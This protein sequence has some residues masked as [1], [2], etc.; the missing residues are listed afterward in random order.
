MANI[1]NTLD[2]ERFP[3]NV[4][5]VYADENDEIFTNRTNNAAEDCKI[6]YK[7][8]EYKWIKARTKTINIF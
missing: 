7:F 6:N 3:V 5:A 2:L 8:I 4:V 1:V